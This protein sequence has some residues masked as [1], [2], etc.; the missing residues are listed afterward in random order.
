MNGVHTGR[1]AAEFSFMVFLRRS[2]INLLDIKIE[3]LSNYV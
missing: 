2:S 3:D 1:V